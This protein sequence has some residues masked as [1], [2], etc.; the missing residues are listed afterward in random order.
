MLGVFGRLQ[1]HLES[2]VTSWEGQG[3]DEA[4]S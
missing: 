3:L 2:S 1:G 4:F